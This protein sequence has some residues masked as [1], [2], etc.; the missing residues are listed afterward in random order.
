MTPDFWAGTVAASVGWL[1][2]YSA[3]VV[4]WL[5]R[6][7]HTRAAEMGCTEAANDRV[8]KI[9]IGLRDAVAGRVVMKEILSSRQMSVAEEQAWRASFGSQQKPAD[10]DSVNGR[11]A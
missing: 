6:D 9:E 8:D 2:V 1:L 3:A 5:W 11:L 7:I 10:L 4:F